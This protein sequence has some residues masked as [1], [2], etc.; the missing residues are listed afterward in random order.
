MMAIS[1]RLASPMDQRPDVGLEQPPKRIVFLS[2]EGSETEKQY[3]QYIE[4][5][6]HELS[7]QSV[8]HVEVLSRWSKDT[9]SDPQHVYDLMQ[10]YLDIR[11]NGIQPTDI[12]SKIVAG[13]E[14]LFSMENITAFM[15]GTLNPTEMYLYQNELR[16]VNIDYEYQKFLSTYKGEDDNDI[17][18]VV[19]DRD[20]GS[21][22]EENIRQL[23]KVCKENGIHC[24]ITNPCF[25][26]WLLLHICNIEEEL[27][28]HYSDLLENAKVSNKHTYVSHEL[29]CRVHHAKTIGENRFIQ[30]YLHNLDIA[31]ER[32]RKLNIDEYALLNH[33]GSN[34]PTLFDIL[35]Q[36]IY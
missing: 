10:E 28:D 13:K 31:I 7:I 3:F 27:S 8:I 14:D 18:A 5:Y 12:F 32:A 23:Y 22:S 6:K 29:S 16:C 1:H 4:K 26:F 34:L 20:K 15:N 33:L 25:E 21:H 2:V 17:F 9:K 30:Y 35:R 24:F 11:N 19:I 36:R